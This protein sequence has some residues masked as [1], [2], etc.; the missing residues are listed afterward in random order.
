VVDPAGTD[1]TASA[2]SGI[3][4]V[5]FLGDATGNGAYSGLD[6]QR[7][8]RVAVGLDAGFA[9]YPKIDPAVIADVTSNGVLS[10][11]D[12]QRIAQEAVGLDS[13]EIPPIPQPLR[14]HVWPNVGKPARALRDS[15]YGPIVETRAARIVSFGYDEAVIREDRQVE[16]LDSSMRL[17]TFTRGQTVQIDINPA[18]RGCYV[19]K[20]EGQHRNTEVQP[21]SPHAAFRDP[22]SVD[23][24]MA[25]LGELGLGL[26]RDPFDEDTAQGSLLFGIR[27]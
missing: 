6:A 10:G 18:D 5:A 2:D 21:A 26:D 12:A 7:V 24:L 4:A 19:E 13:G 22:R 17:L 11:L 20:R 1:V 16:I 9:A 23:R 14:R 15:Q 8:A 25:V 3:H 27:N